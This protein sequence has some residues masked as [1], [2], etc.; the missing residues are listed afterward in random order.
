MPE[1]STGKKKVPGEKLGRKG[2]LSFAVVAVVIFTFPK[3]P[4]SLFGVLC[5]SLWP[6]RVTAK[7]RSVRFLRAH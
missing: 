4:S 1:E 3:N 7:N 5:S 6:A 2:G